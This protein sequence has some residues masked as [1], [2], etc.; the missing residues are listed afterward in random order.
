[1]PET[2][3]SPAI[4]S[5][6]SVEKVHLG[7]AGLLLTVGFVS[8]A[9]S[10]ITLGITLALL[11][12]RRLV[13]KHPL[14][15]TG[16]ETSAALIALWALITLP[17]STDMGTSVLFY[18]RFY[19]FA[20]LWVLAMVAT[21]ERRRMFL[22]ACALAGAVAISL[23]G[24]IKLVTQ[25]GTLFGARFSAMSNP[26]TSGSLL[27][28]MVLLGAGFLLTGGHTRR[29]RLMVGAALVPILLAVIL[30]MTRSALLGLLGG[31][32][33]M[34]ML[35]HRRWFLAFAVAAVV[36]LTVLLTLG[37]TFLP[38]AY[39]RRLSLDYQLSGGNT[40][41]RLEMWR[42]GWEMVKA[43]PLT[44]WGDRSLDTLGPDYYGD[45]ETVYHG[46][47]HNNF[48]QMAV[49]WGV[50]GLVLGLFFLVTP[51]V[52]LLRRWRS[53]RACATAPPVLSGWV[54]GGCGM[55]LGFFLAGFTEWYFGDAE[56]MLIYLAILGT[57]LGKDASPSLNDPIESNAEVS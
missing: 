4:R 15:R 22:L 52:L 44:G 30:T 7:L 16:L 43:R 13:L 39:Q 55:W 10:Q 51:L 25:T 31:L 19:I 35:S 29:V 34:L 46:H 12:F 17:F 23:F 53:L 57:A 21:T 37:H 50:P 6:P 2:P 38:A 26:M 54:L 3:Q 24:E 36:G 45:E 42:G 14:P 32:G 11:L 1:M 56:S 49:I 33:L 8:I 27:M 18:R 9:V 28:M 41:V 47:L 40:N 5:L 48:V 20:A